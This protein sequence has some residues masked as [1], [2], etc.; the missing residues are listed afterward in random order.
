MSLKNTDPRI[1]RTKALIIKSLVKLTEATPYKKI[2]IQDITQNAG[3]ARQTFYLHYKSKD[4]VLIDYIDSVFDNFYQEIEVH[5]IASPDP[6]EIIAWNL[7]NQWQQH[8]EFAKLIIAA[9]VE[10]LVI[11]SFRN[12]ITRVM[13]LYI[14]NHSIAL[15]D[16]EALGFIVDYLAGASWMILQRW[17]TSD[18]NYPLEKLAKLYSELSRPGLLSVINSESI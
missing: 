3:L 8:A 7:F 9:D 16:P 1:I 12:Y 14:R 11:K 17:V 5:I 10:N 4:A 18:F 2:K 13:G 15:N 6:G